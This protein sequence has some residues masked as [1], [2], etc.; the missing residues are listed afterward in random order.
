MATQSAIWPA[1]L[2]H[3]R[4]NSPEPDR[5]ATFYG[6]ALGYEVTDLGGNLFRLSGPDRRLLIGPGGKQ[7]LG[8][9]AFDLATADRLAHYQAH[10]TA[11]GLSLESSPS[12]MLAGEAFSVRDPDGNALVFGLAE[13]GPAPQGLPGRLQHVVVQS[14]APE[15]IAAF[16]EHDLGFVLSDWVRDDAGAPMAGFLR[17]DP[18][19]HSFAVFHASGSRLDHH[20]YETT[21]WNDIRDWAD[22]LARLRVALWWGPGRHGP[23][24]NLFFM[25]EDP[26]GNK[27]EL[28]AEQ[29]LMP[30][31]MAPR[32][33]PANAR[34]LNLWGT[35]WIRE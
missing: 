29:E 5:L 30:I 13:P 1:R 4:I 24:D 27:I 20:A 32:E 6:E 8:F 21:C 17:S 33:W 9:A 11:R 7:T 10:L 3:I 16:Y 14:A 12:P 35:A 25:I 34:T 28:S 31:D 26:D 23:G 18:E 15:P 2:H 19:H 22:H